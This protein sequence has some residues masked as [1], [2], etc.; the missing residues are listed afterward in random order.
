MTA[1]FHFIQPTNPGSNSLIDSLG[2]KPQDFPALARSATLS[3]LVSKGVILVEGPDTEKLL[4]GQ[5]TC[6]INQLSDEHALKGALCDVKG[7]MISS[8]ICMTTMSGATLLIMHREL[9]EITLATLKK[10]AVFYKVTLTDASDDYAVFGVH[11]DKTN[12]T[13]NVKSGVDTTLADIAHGLQLVVCSSPHAEQFWTTYSENYKPCG[14]NF[15]HYLMIIHGEGE[16]YPN[17]SGE[18]IPQMLNLQHT[19]AVNFR[20]GCY[21]GQEIIARMQYLGKLKRRMY[22]LLIRSEQSTNTGFKPGDKIDIEG[23]SDVGTVVSVAI[24]ANG[25]EFLAVRTE[26]AANAPTLCIGEVGGSFEVV[27]LPYDDK[28]MAAPK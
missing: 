17:T 15:W 27:P 18:F 4:Q 11:D 19:N 3:P 2:E 9:V 12:C 21:T 26:E 13:I 14:E 28:F 5:L 6:D 24:S 25:I 1:A 10:Y 7:R 8:L 16:V 23:K 20:K 22:H